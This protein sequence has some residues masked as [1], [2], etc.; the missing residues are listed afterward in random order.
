MSFEIM[1]AT[2]FY[3]VGYKRKKKAES[4]LMSEIMDGLQVI[5]DK[6][7]QSINVHSDSQLAVQQILVEPQ[8]RDAN[9]L[10]HLQCKGLMS[11]VT[12]IQVQFCP[13]STNLVADYIVKTC[14]AKDIYCNSLFVNPLDFILSPDA[15]VFELIQEDKP[16]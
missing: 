8:V 9:F 7:W 1:Q 3:Y 2:G 10:L 14:R 4:V 6:G 11:K 5:V 13:R 15:T 16:P 12:N